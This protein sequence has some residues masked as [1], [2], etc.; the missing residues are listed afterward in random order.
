MLVWKLKFNSK[1]NWVNFGQ[2]II[3]RSFGV[4]K[5]QILILRLN[6]ERFNG[7]SEVIW[8]QQRSYND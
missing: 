3:K 8:D 6:Q 7:G 1:S 4:E 2:M 5:G